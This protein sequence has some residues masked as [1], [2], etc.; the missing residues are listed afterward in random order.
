MARETDNENSA[1]F[2]PPPTQN[3]KHSRCAPI[4]RQGTG[5]CVTTLR[6]TTH[7]DNLSQGCT[8]TG[9][10]E[11]RTKLSTTGSRALRSFVQWTLSDECSHCLTTL[12]QIGALYSAEKQG[13]IVNCENIRAAKTPAGSIYVPR[14]FQR[15]VSFLH[16]PVVL[17]LMV[18]GSQNL[19]PFSRRGNI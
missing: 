9:P 19:R 5:I 7:T 1:L 14:G 8:I 6:P 16:A 11:L 4:F 12:S 10:L 15:D 2:P 3:E 18:A 17:I 13:L